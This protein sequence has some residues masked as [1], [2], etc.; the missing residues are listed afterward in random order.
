MI[1][2]IQVVDVR[3][4]DGDLAAATRDALGRLVT[5][6]TEIVTIIRGADADWR[7]L[8]EA[9]A[10]VRR[11]APHLQTELLLGGSAEIAASVGAE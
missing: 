10:D 2:G 11:S 8:Q 6:D 3:T 9:L 1:A 7:V 4:G 5:D